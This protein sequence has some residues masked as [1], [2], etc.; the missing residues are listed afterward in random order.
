MKCGAKWVVRPTVGLGQIF[1][2]NFI[3]TAGVRRI[4]SGAKFSYTP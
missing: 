1:E 4:K 2:I 3:N